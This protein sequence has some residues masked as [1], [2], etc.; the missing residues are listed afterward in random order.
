MALAAADGVHSTR[1]VEPLK[2]RPWVD[3][4]KRTMGY[5][6]QQDGAAELVHSIDREA[7][8]LLHLRRCARCAR[9][10]VIRANDVRRLRHE[11]QSR[12]LSEVEER[13]KDPFKYARVVYYKGKKAA[14]YVAE[15]SVVLDQPARRGRKRNGQTTQR[16]VPGPPLTLR[17][18]LA[19]V[20]DQNGC[21][22]ATWRWWTNLPPTVDAATSALWYYWR[23]RIEAFHKRLKRA[24]QALEQWQQT[25]VER[26]ARRLLSAAQACAI[27]WALE[28]DES[29]AA[30]GLR[31]LLLR[32]DGRQMRPG[33]AHTTPALLAGCWNL[34][35]IIDAL[36]D[37]SVAELRQHAAQLYTMLG[38]T[39]DHVQEP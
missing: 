16:E 19:Q 36:D 31:S 30:H 14:P 29:A 23:W 28:Q 11:G 9:L 21:V 20:R 4:I 15:T 1:R 26:R 6:A 39:L 7:D 35:S 13:L 25:T 22:L 24:G 18:L 12:L 8:K 5:L 17:L 34:R 2:P 27:V 37:Y 3:E 32:L 33:V 10:V 38:L